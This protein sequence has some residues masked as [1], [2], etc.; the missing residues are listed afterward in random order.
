VTTAIVSGLSAWVL[1]AA[2]AAL[3]L[4]AL[5]VSHG[6]RHREGRRLQRPEREQPIDL[7][8]EWNAYLASQERHEEAIALRRVA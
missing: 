1:V 5:W 6:I 8:A 4:W 2:F 7:A 3:C